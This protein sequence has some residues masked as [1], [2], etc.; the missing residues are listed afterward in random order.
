MLQPTAE[1][2][3]QTSPAIQA[4]VPFV[5]VPDL[6]AGDRLTATDVADVCL[7]ST[8]AGE[9]QS[10][11]ETMPAR[12]FSGDQSMKMKP[13]Q[14]LVAEIQ[15]LQRQRA[16]VLKSRIMQENRLTAIVAGTLGYRSGLEE[17]ERTKLFKQAAAVIDSVV[18]GKGESPLKSVILTTMVGINAFNEMKRELEKLMTKAAKKLAVAAWVE[19]PEQRGFGM[20]FLA[21]VIGETGDLSNYANPAKVW[22]RMGC[23]P[24]TFNGETKMGC[25]WRCGKEG[26]LPS[27]EWEAFGYSPRRRSIAYLIG[28]GIVKQNTMRGR[29]GD[30]A[31]EADGAHTGPYRARYDAAK[32]KA[33]E[34]HPDWSAKR[35]HLHGM[36]LATKLLL[37]NLW[38]EWNR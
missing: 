27:E 11:T 14:N 23:A 9:R 19:Q 15:A 1:L 3:P 34:A 12:T 36:L 10:A 35:C 30:P 2:A 29:G 7:F 37:K 13:S 6:W 21:I 22:R 4:L 26:R 24:W 32:V 18:E 16:V 31:G 5:G 28:E 17:K 33:K 25:T 8:R 20:L 38:V